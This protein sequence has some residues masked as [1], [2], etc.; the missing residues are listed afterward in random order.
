MNLTTFINAAL[1]LHT[2]RPQF[3]QFS[4]HTA[5]F[6][7]LATLFTTFYLNAPISLIIL[8][9]IAALFAYI[10]LE[11]DVSNFGH[12]IRGQIKCVLVRRVAGYLK[13]RGLPPSYPDTG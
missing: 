3:Q 7:C 12:G 5:L 13:A 11:G 4:W 2:W 9:A 10:E 1:H 8:L 6:G